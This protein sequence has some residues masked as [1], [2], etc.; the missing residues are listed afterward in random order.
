MS[1]PIITDN[2]SE[3]TITLPLKR[4]Y[5]KD[6]LYLLL[7]I[8]L[9]QLILLAGLGCFAFYEILTI[10]KPVYF[11]VNKE[12]QIIEPIPLAKPN[13]TPAE[14]LTWSVESM[15]TAFSFNYHN[16]KTHLNK[17]SPFFDNR[18]VEKFF[19]I[20]A[21]DPNIGLVRQEKLVVSAKALEAPKLLQDGVI[22]NRYVWKI[23]LPLEIRYENAHILRKRQGI[24]ELYI[25]R[26]PNIEAAKGIK[27]TNLM[28]TFKN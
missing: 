24:I 13:L 21:S 18:G 6:N 19:E 25:W 12:N 5:L 17:I 14:I 2:A 8:F 11:Q 1:N 20:L 16:I 22:D 4:H 3:P 28:V 10:P 15:Q 7:I 26:M 9:L 27:I 23:S